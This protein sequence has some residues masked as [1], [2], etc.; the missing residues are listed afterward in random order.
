ML[1]IK[2]DISRFLSIKVLCS[3]FWKKIQD[4]F[5]PNVDKKVSHKVEF[6]FEPDKNHAPR[7]RSI[8]TIFVCSTAEENRKQLMESS[9]FLHKTIISPKYPL[10]EEEME[11]STK[12]REHLLEILSK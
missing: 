8:S 9:D 10:Y 2:N 11:R 12:Y 4:K 5:G 6:L 3:K 1:I 7:M